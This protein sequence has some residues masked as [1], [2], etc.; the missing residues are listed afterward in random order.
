[1]KT[2]I[3]PRL[4]SLG[5]RPPIVSRSNRIVDAGRGGTFSAGMVFYSFPHPEERPRRQI[6]V[7]CVNL[8]TCR[9]SKDEYRPPWFETR[10]D[11]L[12]TMRV[13]LAGGAGLRLQAGALVDPRD[14]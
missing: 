14:A 7:A 3:S 6:Y 4:L 9:V 1:M 5:P 12:L 13:L 11:A 8:A 2:S 10:E